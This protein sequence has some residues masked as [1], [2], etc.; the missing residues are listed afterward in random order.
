MSAR[1]LTDLYED[2]WLNFIRN[3]KIRPKIIDN[4][5]DIFVLGLTFISYARNVKCIR[6]NVL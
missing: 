4:S 5:F 3:H 6:Y 2:K 1:G